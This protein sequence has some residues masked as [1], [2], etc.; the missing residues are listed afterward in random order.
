MRWTRYSSFLLVAAG[1]YHLRRAWSSAITTDEAF[2]ANDFA[3]LPWLDLFTRYDANHHILH[4]ILCK[5]SLSAFGWNELALR[6]PSLLAGFVWLYLIHCL[7]KRLFG[8]S[9]L[10]FVLCGWL[11]FHPALLDWFSLAR[12]YSLALAFMLAAIYELAGPL[13]RLTRASLW[14]G[15]SVASNLV[16]AVPA[17]ALVLG[18]TAARRA[19]PRLPDLAVPGASVAL[20]IT[21]IPL[22]RSSG[23]NFY[24]GS[25]TLANSLDSLVAIPHFEP[26][27]PLLMIAAPAVLAAALWFARQDETLRFFSWSLALCVLATAAMRAV[28]VPYPLGRTGVHLVA[29][30]ILCLL[31]MLSLV[32]YHWIWAAALAPVLA[33]LFAVP[34]GYY[35]MWRYDSANRAVMERIA[36]SGVAAPKVAAH[37]TMVSGLEF[38][39]RMPAFSHIAPLRRTKDASGAQFIVVRTDDDSGPQP[40]PGAEPVWRDFTSGIVLYK[41]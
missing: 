3:S 16:F 29:L 17:T 1:V 5:L 2:T 6:A 25:T 4:T 19:W 9:P 33:F 11:A 41:R 24:Y 30:A 7:A 38:Y 26:L 39:R 40:P 35:P 36:A 10:H 20:V 14:L 12:G 23:S 21:I 28:G 34:N 18:W 22:S 32:R 37:F 8:D 13:P 15:L 31:Q 27:T